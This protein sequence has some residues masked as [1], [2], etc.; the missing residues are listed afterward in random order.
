M[1]S[2]QFWYLGVLALLVIMLEVLVAIYAAEHKRVARVLLFCMATFVLSY[3]IGLFITTRIM[4]IAFSTFSYF[5]FGIAVFL[6]VRPFKSAA[7]FCSFLSGVAYMSVFLVYPNAIYATL[8]DEKERIVG[9]VLHSLML[10]GSLLLYGQ[11]KV[12]KADVYY[13]L[14]FVAFI[15]VY[16][17]VAVRICGSVQANFLTLGI[18]EAT[19][20][21]YVVPDFVIRW[22]W[23]ILWYALAAVAIWAMW[24]WTRFINNKLVRQ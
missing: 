5:L 20:I 6:P 19:L 12:A 16:T 13:I 14:G 4:P 2:Q 24:E 22:W 18:V 17:E 8:P 9:F 23:Y 10:F 1:F 15:A 7:A 11:Y 21:K 3:Q